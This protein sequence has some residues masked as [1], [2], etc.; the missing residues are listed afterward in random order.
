MTTPPSTRLNCVRTDC[1]RDLV[2]AS[3]ATLTG[4]DGAP[5]WR[6]ETRGSCRP[7]P[8]TL[9]L[10]GAFYNSTWIFMVKQAAINRACELQRCPLDMQAAW[11]TNDHQPL[12][13]I[14][15]MKWRVCS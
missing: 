6:D 2:P 7:P 4:L 3:V 13:F 11:R 12:V 5:S 10:C 9:R 14:V 8:K 15:F 1:E